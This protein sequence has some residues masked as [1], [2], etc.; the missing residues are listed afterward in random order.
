MYLSGVEH[1]EKPSEP[2]SVVAL[3]DKEESKYPGYSKQ[4]HYSDSE[5]ELFLRGGTI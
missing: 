1:D 4:R 2:D 5:L 3:D